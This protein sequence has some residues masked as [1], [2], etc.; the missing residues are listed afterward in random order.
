MPEVAQNRAET[1][2][3]AVDQISDLLAGA[4]SQPGPTDGRI[5]PEETDLEAATPVAE[6]G[7]E[8][9][10][11]AGEGE[12]PAPSQGEIHDL[13]GLAQAIGV[14]PEWL[15]S[16]K[17]PMP[18]GRD[19]LTLGQFKD[20]ITQVDRDRQ[21]IEKQRIELA[22]AEA[23]MQAALDVTQQVPQAVQAAYAEVAA[24]E[25]QYNSID[26]ATVEK[27]N[28]GQAALARQKMNDAYAAAKANLGQ[29][30]QKAQAMQ[31]QLF[32]QQR[33]EQTAALLEK[34]PEWKDKATAVRERDLILTTM[35]EYDIDPREL[36]V[37]N[38]HRYVRAMRDL[39]LLKQQSRNADAS[40]KQVRQAPK[41]L[42][43]VANAAARQQA[44][45]RQQAE[46]VRRAK[47]LGTPAAQRAAV[48]N[49]LNLKG[50]L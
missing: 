6:E 3:S 17:M 37:V 42:R 31:Q 24:I 45:Q 12:A 9:A 35:S 11:E 16:L 30:V 7:Q 44:G 22:Q 10:P 4:P 36:L 19:P 1:P 25:Q 46:L 15:Y 26:W 27:R 41:T 34:V 20:V 21:Q 32:E 48:A 40:L 28:P 18:D 50:I 29:T 23:R 5:P 14:D 39:A 47:E 13:A 38:D 2:K 43:P 33:L 49:L 8:T